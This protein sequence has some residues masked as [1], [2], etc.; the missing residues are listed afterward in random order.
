MFLLF[1]Q[2]GGAQKF[3][4]PPREKPA[5]GS[6]TPQNTS[7][8]RVK[9][10]GFLFYFAPHRKKRPVCLKP[11]YSGAL[12]PG[13]HGSAPTEPAGETPGHSG[14]SHAY[15]HAKA[16]GSPGK[17][18]LPA[19]EGKRDTPNRERP[20]AAPE[21]PKN[22]D[23]KK[24]F[25][26]IVRAAQSV[27]NHAHKKRFRYHGIPPP[28]GGPGKR[29][30]D[31]RE[32]SERQRRSAAN[33]PTRQARWYFQLWRSDRAGGT[34]F[35]VSVGVWGAPLPAALVNRMLY[36]VLYKCDA[37]E[38]QNSKRAFVVGKDSRPPLFCE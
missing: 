13:G 6:A 11:L 5:S 17:A 22:A 30:G 8:F 34:A 35:L 10:V 18:P 26:G 1:E 32:V 25:V 21:T 9:K 27:Q 15:T 36:K 14:K 24:G 37:G 29:T 38:S 31:R 4:G 33:R 16:R 20:F 3:T 28:C 2:A 19:Q 7:D 12:V 23:I